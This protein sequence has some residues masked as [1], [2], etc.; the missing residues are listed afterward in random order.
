MDLNQYSKL[1]SDLIRSTQH[2][3]S[4]IL[5]T[6]MT[7]HIYGTKK[8]FSEICSTAYS[9]IYYLFLWSKANMNIIS[10]RTFFVCLKIKIKLFANSYLL[11]RN[12]MDGLIITI[13]Q[14]LEEESAR[15]KSAVLAT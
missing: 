13:C 4:L 3:M 6:T 11:S 2:L 14:N 15:L 7:Q 10:N 12:L 8:R 5:A 1:G 9:V